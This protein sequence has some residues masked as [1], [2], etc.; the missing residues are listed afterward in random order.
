MKQHHVHKAHPHH[1][2]WEQ[3]TDHR[4]RFTYY[5]ARHRLQAIKINPGEYFVTHD[6][7]VLVTV[8]GSCV[9]ACIRDPERH[10]GGM[11]HFMLPE[12]EM[13][14]PATRSA[15][16]GSYAMELLINELLKH[17]AAR[18]RLEA[19]VFGGG[20]VL[21]S[22]TANHVGAQNADFVLQYLAAERI[23][24]VAQDLG[25]HHA[26]K[27]HFF[28]RSGRVLMATPAVKTVATDLASERAG[29]GGR[30]FESIAAQG[31]VELF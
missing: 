10:L 16:Y 30:A 7:V 20:N 26:R 17:G 19:K 28:P 1:S 22:I 29:M 24:I 5:E 21:H 8:L 27:L 11:N 14:G 31:D 4:A 2:A 12:S 25:H 18:E 15:R 23:P 6:D 3:P 9:S 13:P